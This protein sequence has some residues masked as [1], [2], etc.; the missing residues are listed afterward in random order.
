MSELLASFGKPFAYQVAAYRLRLMQLA[1]T[2]KWDDLWQAEHDVALMVAG[3]KKADILADFAVMT[4]K[5]VRGG[6]LEEFRRDFRAMVEKKGWQIS[7]P[8]T[9]GDVPSAGYQAWRTKVIYKTN[10]SASYAAGRMAQ[11]R[12]GGYKFFVY[13]HG[14]SLEP[15][16]QHLAWDGLVLPADHPFWDTHAPPNGWGCTCRIAGARSRESA[17]RVGGKPEKELPDDWRR[18]DAETGAPI[19]IDRGWAYSPGAR[20]SNVIAALAPKIMDLPAPLAADMVASWPDRVMRIW[21]DAFGQFVDRALNNRVEKNFMIVGALKPEWVKAARER[22]VQITS[23][24]IVVDDH[25]IQHTFRG[26]GLGKAVAPRPNI[27]PKKAPLDLSWYRDLP[28]HL[29]S[30]KAVL[31]DRRKIQ[32]VLQLIYDVPGSAAKLIVEVNAHIHKAKGIMNLMQSGRLVKLSD[33]LGSLGDKVELIE[34]VL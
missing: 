7:K 23:A 34:G 32:P 25:A 17:H 27:E 19:G 8:D 24:E 22:E 2:T 16:L 14:N 9:E 10:M 3:A 4:D 13:L 26:T 12:E 1:P 33:I 31:L 29:R 20:V 15:R 5:A 30:P 18:V 6:T 11:L 21:A 28:L